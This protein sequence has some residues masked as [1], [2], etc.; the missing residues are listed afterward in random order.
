M[1]GP[2]HGSGTGAWPLGT[3]G[4]IPPPL[5]KV[6]LNLGIAAEDKGIR[7]RQPELPVREGTQWEG[8]GPDAP[9]ACDS[10]FHPR[11]LVSF[12]TFQK[13]APCCTGVK[14]TPSSCPGL[15]GGLGENNRDR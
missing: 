8:T 3:G 4:Q 15:T 9:L 13:P 14:G 1:L 12:T 6:R 10:C 11:L 7:G 5:A 2:R